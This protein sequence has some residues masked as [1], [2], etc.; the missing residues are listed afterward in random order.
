LVA[1]TTGPECGADIEEVRRGL[2][3][4]TLGR[5]IE[6]PAERGIIRD[7]ADFYRLWT[8]KEAILK[9]TGDGLL[10]PMSGLTLEEPGITL[11]PL[12]VSGAFIAT[13]AVAAAPPILVELVDCRT[14]AGAPACPGVAL[15]FRENA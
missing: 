13:L 5:L 7:A 10:A 12:D 11:W 9:C 14:P 3:F 15:G 8:S 1:A 6:S 2:D 4:A